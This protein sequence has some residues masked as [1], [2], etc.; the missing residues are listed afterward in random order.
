MSLLISILIVPP[1]ALE[2]FIIIIWDYFYHNG[3]F[4]VKENHSVFKNTIK[5]CYININAATILYQP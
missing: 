4:G 3:A 5:S 2:I 1:V